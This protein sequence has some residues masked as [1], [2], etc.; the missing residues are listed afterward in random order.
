MLNWLW[1]NAPL[2]ICLDASQW[3][4]YRSGIV[5]SS[6]CERSIDHCVLL[7]GY[8]LGTKP[9]SWNVRNSWGTGWGEAGYIQL[10]YDADTCG[11]ATYPASCHTVA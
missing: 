9:P 5:L 1:G 2:S 11:M 10:Q 7:T 6:H 8:N 4:S 3:M